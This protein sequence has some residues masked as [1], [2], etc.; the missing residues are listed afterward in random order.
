MPR[1]LLAGALLA[2]PTRAEPLGYLVAHEDT[3]KLREE[4]DLDQI[5]R[6]QIELGRTLRE[7]M[8]EMPGWQCV[9]DGRQAG[10]PRVVLGFDAAGD[11]LGLEND[12]A[13]KLSLTVKGLGRRESP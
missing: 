9:G 10:A 8:A 7:R 3:I 5:T 4:L 13:I 1:T 6:I 11:V 12:Y 2:H